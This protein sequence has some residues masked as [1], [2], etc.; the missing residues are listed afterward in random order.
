M[1]K[2]WL[3]FRWNLDGSFDPSRPILPPFVFRGAE[4]DEIDVV[5]NVVSSALMMER[6]WHGSG[7]EIRTIFEQQTEEAF[8]AKPPACVV[9]QH[10]TRIIGASIL[11]MDP[12]AETNL[13]SGPCILHEYRSRGLGSALLHQSLERLRLAGLTSATGIA[14]VNSTVARYVYPKF[15]G[16]EEPFV[17]PPSQLAA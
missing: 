15:G 5:M 9:V 13:V 7:T 1:S 17:R 12:N 11:C 3:Q 16:V 4:S 8:A 14:R 6:A 10:G 2:E